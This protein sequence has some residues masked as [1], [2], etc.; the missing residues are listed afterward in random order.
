MRVVITGGTGLIGQALVEN[1]HEDY[2]VVVL[3][4]SPEKY[5]GD[6]PSGVKL[7]EYDA[8]TADGWVDQVDG[9]FAI[10]NLAGAGIAD[11]RWS[12]ER[13]Q[14]ILDSRVD[15]GHAVTEAIR[16]AENKPKVLIQ[17]SAVGIYGDRADEILTEHSPDGEG[18]LAD[19]VRA[20]EKSTNEVEGMGVRRVLIRTGVVLSMEGGALPK[21]KLPFNFGAG[22]DLG[23]GEQWF[24]WIHIEDEVR[25]IR[26]LMENPDASG[27]YNLTAPTPEKNRTV[28]Q[29]MGTVLNR[30]VFVPAVPRFALNLALGDMA[31]TVLNSNR[32]IPERLRREGFA[33]K[34]SQLENALRDLL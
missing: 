21:L 27:I 10:V 28:T 7:V 23:D 17:S 25:A 29:K 5:K 31:A 26:W 19:V 6:M 11:K 22:G 9:A 14:V 8:D 16:R 12:D 24:P 34:F 30:P 15:V 3:S 2:E 4:R 18:F 33:F 1:L 13:K 32:V 20:W